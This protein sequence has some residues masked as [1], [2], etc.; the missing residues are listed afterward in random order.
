MAFFTAILSSLWTT[1][2]TPITVTNGSKRLPREYSP[3]SLPSKWRATI[4]LVSQFVIF[5]TLTNSN[6]F[7][8]RRGNAQFNLSQEQGPGRGEAMK[9]G[10]AYLNVWMWVVKEMNDAIVKCKNGE[11]NASH[12]IDKAVAFYAGSL[13]VTE[14]TEGIMLYALA[15]VRARQFKTGGQSGDNEDGEAYVNLEVI[16]NFNDT[17]SFLR[18]TNYETRCKNAEDSVNRIITLMKVP[19]IQSIL[20]Y[21]Y[22]RNNELPPNEVDRERV[23]AECATY[24][25]TM[26]PYI[27]H[28]SARDASL[29]HEHMRIGQSDDTFNSSAV[30]AALERNYACMGISCQEVGGIWDSSFQ[31]Y[32]PGAAPCNEAFTSSSGK[33]FVSTLGTILGILIGLLRVG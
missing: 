8:L 13:T 10:S 27:H 16:R 32:K 30:R 2:E 25:A 3:I 7:E 24:A 26:L 17:Q 22:I 9:K 1:T 15:D 23:K 12:S 11:D 18:S 4:H 5:L 14:K 19:L 29:I 31:D 28:C 6:I 21:A 33:N 20:R